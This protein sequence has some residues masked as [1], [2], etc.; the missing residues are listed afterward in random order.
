M[1]LVYEDE[2][3]NLENAYNEVYSAVKQTEDNKITEAYTF[4]NLVP[5]SNSNEIEESYNKLKEKAETALNSENQNIIKAA[6]QNLAKLE[7]HFQFLYKFVHQKELE[8]DKRIIAITPKNMVFVKGGKFLM[9][10]GT[11]NKDS[12]VCEVVVSSFFIDKYPL[13][14]KEFRDFSEQNEIPMPKPPPWGWHDDHPMVNITWL[15][16]FV[17]S[18]WIGKRL[19]TEAEW[20]FAARGGIKTKKFTYSGSNKIEDVAW[21]LA[22]SD[23]ITNPVALKKPN[24][25]GIFDMSGNVW[26][27]CNDWYAEYVESDNEIINPLGPAE[28]TAKVLRGGSHKVDKDY[29]SVA[30]RLFHFPNHFNESWGVRFV[31]DY[32]DSLSL[33]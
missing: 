25:L 19:P 21:Y 12:I 33:K 15:E 10:D 23:N 20:E 5:G 31:Q 14:V 27:W 30:R 9:G 22:N 2:L 3:L 11:K 13:L 28:G 16:A 26:E 6:K 29:C 1:K 8:A 17:Y 32:S 24:E 7:T 18:R 4:L